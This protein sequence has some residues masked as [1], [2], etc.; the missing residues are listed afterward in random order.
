MPPKRKAP[1]PK[2]PR[3]PDRRTGPEVYADQTSA[4][5]LRDAEGC[6]RCPES[7]TTV[8]V[9]RP[10]GEV[11]CLPCHLDRDPERW[12]TAARMEPTTPE[13]RPGRL[14]R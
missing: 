11:C 10:S 3:K 14:D 8:R 1:K 12:N 9:A 6:S 13:N 5:R 4:R 7:E 2:P